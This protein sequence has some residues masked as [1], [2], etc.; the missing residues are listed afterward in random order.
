MSRGP[1]IGTALSRALVADARRCDCEITISSAEWERWASATFSGAR[2]TLS[3]EATPGA[4][5]DHWLAELPEANI[6]L[7]GHLLADLTASAVTRGA[8][9]CV[10][11]LEALT[12]ETSAA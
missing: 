3:V 10:I 7:R 2:H 1:D 11:T 5:L 9:T 8:G 6:A 4:R 12:V